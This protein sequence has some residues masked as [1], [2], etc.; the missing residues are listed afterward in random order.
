M[1][2]TEQYV[3]SYGEQGMEPPPP[4]PGVTSVPTHPDFSC[5][6]AE[7]DLKCSVS[8]WEGLCLLT[9]SWQGWQVSGGMFWKLSC[10][11]L[12]C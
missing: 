12:R 10:S 2:P 8:T 1:H 5:T 6:V 7:P 11:R 9:P 3:I 4:P